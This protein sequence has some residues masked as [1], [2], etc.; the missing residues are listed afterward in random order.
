MNGAK[1]L[2]ETLLAAGVDTCFANPGTS[3][4]HFVA[5]LDQSPGMKC[6]LGLQENIV[7]G[8]ADGYFRLARKPACTLLHCGPGLA[9]GMGNLHNARRARSGIVN[10]VGDQ[11]TYHR[12]YDAPLTADTAGMARTVS[13]WVRTS[14]RTADLGRDAVDAVRAARTFPGQIATLILPADVSWQEGGVVGVPVDPPSPHAIDGVAIE[15]AARM[16][17][18]NRD[19]LILLAGHGVLADAQQ[20]AWRVACATGATV[21]ASYVNAHLARGRG[22]MQL[23]RVPYGMNQAI[24]AL[25]RFRHII[26][27]NAEPPVG[28]F[29]YPGQPSI[30]H[31]PDARFHVLSRPDQDPVEAL[32]GLV[33][34]LDAPAAAV[35]DPGPRPGPGSGA[36]TPEGLARTL[37]AVMPEH[38]IVSDESIS[39][40]RGFY[41]FT[42]AAPAHDWLHLAGGAI[43]DG[44][45]V[46]TGAAL[47]A[48]RQRRVINLQADGS[49]MYSLQS[50]WTQAREQLPVTTVI[51]NNSKYNILIGEYAS[52]GAVPGDTAMSM[53]DLG[54]P[55]LGWVQLANGM[56]V[57]AA[58]ATTLEQCADLMTS[59]FGRN[60]PFLIEL[61]V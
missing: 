18:D 55:F 59:S 15:G 44:M 28:F 32:R 12:P 25:D 58:R 36:P 27:V 13:A 20:L 37:A 10:I 2:V 39:Y 42:H 50:L 56:G 53:L 14:A 31:H 5:A 52:V 40:G 48:G 11:A 61:M 46:A 24:E 22:R 45:P 34:A 51:L 16:L 7:T 60:A 3:E 6:V 23:E 33:K 38:A 17:R 19:V 41:P 30:Q 29:G 54:N 49:A 57:E 47:G 21:M 35:P 4:M 1:S 9:N 43:G 26:L 8:M